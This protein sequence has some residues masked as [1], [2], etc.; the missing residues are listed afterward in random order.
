MKMATELERLS[1]RS[2]SA[3]SVQRDRNFSSTACRAPESRIVRRARSTALFAVNRLF[4]R[5][6]G[7]GAVSAYTVMACS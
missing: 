2:D 4:S 1:H 3:I 5:S 6:S 7:P